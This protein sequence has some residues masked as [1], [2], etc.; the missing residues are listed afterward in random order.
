MSS[1]KENASI[2]S[3]FRA[4]GVLDE[5]GVIISDR[6]SI[7]ALSQRGYGTVEQDVLTLS[8]YEALYLLDKQ[9]L[10]PQNK[11]GVSIEFQ[12]LLQLYEQKDPNAWMH[13]LV[14]RDLRS[15]GYVVREGFGVA[16]DFR[17]YERGS[18]G[19]DSASF[20]VLSTQEGQP[21]PMEDLG[22]A[23]MQTQSLN[24]EMILAVMNRRG[25]IVY[26]SVSPLTFK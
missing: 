4:K 18:Y 10:T 16:I 2:P 14:Y 8:F 24:K 21:L 26:Y 13:Y 19:K 22:K 23:L 20:L 1:D 12:S 3:E 7:D 11:K 17:I 6:S 15:R 5:K 9:M 25:E